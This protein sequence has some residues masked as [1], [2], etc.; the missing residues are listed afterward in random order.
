MYPPHRSVQQNLPGTGQDFHQVPAHL[1]G[2]TASP[3]PT[4]PDSKNPASDRQ[5]I[6]GNVTGSDTRRIPQPQYG[7]REYEMLIHA[8]NGMKILSL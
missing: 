6:T 8:L 2:V 4:V 5:K 1:A 3:D 7:M